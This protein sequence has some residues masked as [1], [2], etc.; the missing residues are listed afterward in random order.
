MI[1]KKWI[2]IIGGAAFVFVLGNLFPVTNLY[3]K[4][5]VQSHDDETTLVAVVV[6]VEWPLLLVIG[7]GCGLI[8][9]RK[10][11]SN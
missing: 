6:L 8:F 9:Y 10:F 4:G 3:S 5:I 11:L 2:S 1:I 7:A